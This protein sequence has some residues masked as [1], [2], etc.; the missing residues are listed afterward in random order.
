VVEFEKN[1]NNSLK[2]RSFFDRALIK[3]IA[4]SGI[5]VVVGLVLSYLNPFGYFT[6]FGTKINPFAHFINTITGVLIG[7]ILS[8]V[9]AF[10]IAILRFSLSIGSIHAFHGGISGAFVVGIVTHFLRKKAPNHVELAAFT[11][12]LGT[13]FI[14]GTIG[15]LI[16][17]IGGIS[18]VESLFT[19]W[20]L[21]ALSCILGAIMGYIVLITLNRAKITERKKT[22]NKLKESEEKLKKSQEQL[23]AILTNLKDPIFV[24]SEDHEIMFMNQYALEQFEEGYVGRKCYNALFGRNQPC[25]ECPIETVIGVG[26]Y[27]NRIEK[28]ITLP[29]T[30]QMCHFDIKVSLIENFKGKP[31]ILELFRDVT[32][33]KEAE[34]ELKDVQAELAQKERLATLGKLAGGVGHE[35]RNPLAA[36]KNAAYFLNM[37][38]EDLD[39]QVKESLQIIEEEVNS[40]EKIISNLLGYA[41]PKS[42]NIRMIKINSIIQKVLSRTNIPENVEVINRLDAALPAILA[43]PDQLKQVFGNIILNAIQAMPEGGQL[44]VKSEVQ[45]QEEITISFADTGV[46]ISEEGLSKLFEPLYTTKAKGIGLGLAICKT[47]IEKHKGNIEVKSEIKKGSTFSIKLPFGKRG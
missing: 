18:M 8:C 6:I 25:E 45:S 21:F 20:G 19:Y 30:N 11:E 42:I 9:T 26:M 27:Q 34:Q 35:L 43:D 3:R 24:I 33:Q 1:K 17:P 39:P 46:G 12:P 32:K 41:R 13:I 40:S 10:A 5:L 16:A 29:S 15:H 22:E 28:T 23:N 36:I 14:G 2:D 4:T 44:I 38:L 47:I 7:L 31:A 37:A